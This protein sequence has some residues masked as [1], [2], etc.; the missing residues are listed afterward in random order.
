MSASNANPSPTPSSAG[1]R[2]TPPTC[3]MS[4]TPPPRESRTSGPKRER[5]EKCSF[6]REAVVLLCMESGSPGGLSLED[7]ADTGGRC[8]GV[9][10]SGTRV[11]RV[12]PST[13]RRRAHD[14]RQHRV[15]TVRPGPGWE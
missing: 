13:Q 12:H 14:A 10:C 7:A 6:G 15:G 9:W 3:G 11:L 1:A 2:T 4:C 8:C 5:P